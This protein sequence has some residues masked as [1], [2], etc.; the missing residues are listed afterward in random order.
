MISTGHNIKWTH[1]ISSYV[2]H[3]CWKLSATSLLANSPS[4]NTFLSTTENC[5]SQIQRPRVP[6]PRVPRPHVPTS[7]RP[8]VPRP[9]VPASPRPRVP[10]S[11][12]PRVPAS[13]VPASPRPRV[14]KSSRPKSHVPV[15]LLV[16][17]IL[18]RNGSLTTT[19]A[20]LFGF[21]T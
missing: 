10:A 1:L 17:A 19:F 16:T 20:L 8:R 13:P 4:Y 5:K 6:R 2:D 21:D 11:P 14:P 3:G 18:K 12:R 7:P 15:P 9:R